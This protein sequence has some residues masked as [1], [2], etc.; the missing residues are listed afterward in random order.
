[1]ELGWDFVG[2][3]QGSQGNGSFIMTPLQQ[4]YNVKKNILYVIEE[5][6]L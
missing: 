1:L 3:L 2:Y 5:H 6:S 4:Q